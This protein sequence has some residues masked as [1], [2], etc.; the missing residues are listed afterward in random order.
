MTVVR[1]GGNLVKLLMAAF[2]R[3]VEYRTDA[4]AAMDVGAYKPLVSALT[5]ITDGV[6]NALP[7]RKRPSSLERDHP[8]VKQREKALAALVA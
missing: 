2:S 6:N 7:G 8:T 5:K 3:N 4:L 1:V